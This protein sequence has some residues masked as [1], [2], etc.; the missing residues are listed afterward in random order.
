ML[1]NSIQL[2]STYAPAYAE[3]G[4]RSRILGTYAGAGRAQ[5]ERAEQNLRKALAL[6]ETLLYAIGNLASLYVETARREAS[7][8]LLQRAVEINPNDAYTRFCLSYLYR[9]TG[10]LEE[11]EREADLALRLDPRNPRFRSTG[12]TYVYIGKYDKAL[13]AFDVDPGSPFSLTNKGELF[14]RLGKSE[15]A[16]VHYDS[17]MAITREGAAH[18]FAVFYL[19]YIKGRRAEAREAV[20]ELERLDPGDGEQWYSIAILYGLLGEAADCA[21]LLRKAVDSGFFCY[22]YMQKDAFLDPVRNETEMKEVFS[23]AS[24]KFEDFKKLLSPP[25]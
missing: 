20:R 16:V 2:D 25:M 5:M 22:P 19:S 23:L 1:E 12:R 17:S 21:R 18:S 24:K 15:Q 6:N 14:L 4:F 8:R 11:S 13:Q 7:L 10:M 9:Y 3:M